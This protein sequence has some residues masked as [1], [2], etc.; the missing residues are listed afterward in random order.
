MISRENF[1]FLPTFHHHSPC[2]YSMAGLFSNRFQL[3]SNQSFP[4]PFQL[5]V[6]GERSTA[7]VE[8]WG[9]ELGGGVVGRG[10]WG[11]ERKAGDSSVSHSVTRRC[12]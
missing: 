7:G 1:I 8:W 9:G 3:F 4:P 11:V 2:S 12:D 10:L 6:L 5:P